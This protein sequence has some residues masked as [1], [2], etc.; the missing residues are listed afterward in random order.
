MG[1]LGPLL[2]RKSDLSVRNGVLLYK[3]LI[4]PMMDYACPAWRS[5]AHTHVWMLQVLQPKCLCLATGAPWYLSN[6]QIHEDLGSA[7]CRPHQSP[8][9]ELWLKVSWCGEPPSM[10][11]RQ[12]CWSRVD[13]IA[14]HK[15]QGWQGPAGQSRPSP[16]MVKSAKRI[17][18]SIDQPSAFWLPWLRF[19]HD[20]PQL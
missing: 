13:P 5:A 3:Q 20:F 12:I 14:R 10:A 16:A 1:M 18:F 6:R 7:V 11:T 4:C 2:N 9:C 8:D 19:F 15:S 17:T